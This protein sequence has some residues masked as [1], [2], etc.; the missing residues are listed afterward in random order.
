MGPADNLDRSAR[1]GC[2]GGLPP[3]P[4]RFPRRTEGLVTATART[5]TSEQHPPTRTQHAPRPPARRGASRTSSAGGRQARSGSRCYGHLSRPVDAV[6]GGETSPQGRSHQAET[7]S[8][9]KGVRHEFERHGRVRFGWR[10][11]SP[12]SRGAVS[13]KGAAERGGI[14][15]GP[16]HRGG[17]VREPTHLAPASPRRRLGDEMSRTVTAESAGAGLSASSRRQGEDRGRYLTLEQAA[18]AY[19][20]FTLR[21]LRRLVEERRIA[22]SRAG[23]RIVLAEHDIER[24]LEANRVEPRSVS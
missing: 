5:L 3:R 18:Q 17:P 24:Y 23:R 10:P 6:C 2:Q 11:S 16:P 4:Q 15:D 1:A 13:V 14:S 7:E 20:V 9:H 21:L 19:P 8:L 22:F 12:G